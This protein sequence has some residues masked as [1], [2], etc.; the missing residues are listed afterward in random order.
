MPLIGSEVTL[1][2]FDGAVVATTVDGVRVGSLNAGLAKRF[3]DTDAA[4]TVN[5]FVVAYHGSHPVIE[6]AESI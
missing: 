5:A 1:E 4:E 2:E 3:L 6:V